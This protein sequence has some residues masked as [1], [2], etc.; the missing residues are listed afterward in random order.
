MV[1]YLVSILFNRIFDEDGNRLP[2][3]MLTENDLSKNIVDSLPAL[4]KFVLIANDTANYD[5][6]D[7]KLTFYQKCLEMTNLGF[8]EYYVLDD[9]NISSAREILDG[10][11]FILLTGGKCIVQNEFCHKIHLLDILESGNGVCVGVSAGAMN[12]CETVANF[13]EELS[14]LGQPLWLQ[15]IGVCRDIII[16]HFDGK[17]RIY[18]IPCEDIDV[19]KDHVLPLSH[20]RTLLG[21]PN[22]SYIKIENGVVSMHGVYYQIH[23]GDIDQYGE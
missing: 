20:H 22:Y 5:E 3:P 13:P 23:N 6:N 11:D 2:C 8:K 4:N 1:Y 12:M 18:Q 10:A 17:N 15:G 9:R 16:P 7:S 19:V 14:D 21:L